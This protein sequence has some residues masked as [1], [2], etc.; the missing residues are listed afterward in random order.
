MF[1]GQRAES[2]NG[3]TGHGGPWPYTILEEPDLSY[4]V[5][6]LSGH[7]TV[8][9]IDLVSFQPY[10]EIGHN[11][12]R[13]VVE[14]WTIDGQA[15]KFVGIFDG[16]SGH[17]TVN[18]TIEKLPGFIKRDILAKVEGQDHY[19]SSDISNVLKN[20]ISS[21]DND[22]TQGLLSLFPE[23]VEAI[24]K[25][26]DEEIRAVVVVND[27]PHPKIVPAMSGTTA[28]VTLTDPQRNLFVA[29]LG[30]C[31]AVLGRKGADGQ[32]ST[33]I[34]SSN[35][36]GQDAAEAQR[37][38]SEHPGEEECVLK[39]RVLGAIAVTR[40]IGD[41]VFKMPRIFPSRVFNLA[42]PPAYIL[43]RLSVFLPRLLTPPYLSGVPDVQQVALAGTRREDTVLVLCSDGLVDVSK[44]HEK[45]LA[46]VAARWIEV[47]S[48]NMGDKPALR[49]LRDAMGGD[50]KP[51]VSFWLTAEMDTPW[52]D[53][54]TVLVMRV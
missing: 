22:I 8:G 40:A 25:M 39:D 12:D 13:Y 54:T 41:H 10:P 26:T 46:E 32:W 23:G 42:D 21:F 36:N 11:Q 52:V 28:L 47:A 24:E 27:K 29:S 15:W 30:D 19:T 4:H 3:W 51:Q 2:D 43:T 37:V 38:R 49:V 20:A 14:N 5:E 50:D 48:R 44:A 7:Q 18:Y 45:P 6:R 17:S 33:A 1:N 31:Q 53:D 35:H 9:D 16:H 34:L